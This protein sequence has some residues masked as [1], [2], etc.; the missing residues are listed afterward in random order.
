MTR[1]LRLGAT[2]LVVLAFTQ[3]MLAQPASID[4]ERWRAFA[5]GLESAARIEVRLRDGTAGASLHEG[6]TTG[7]LGGVS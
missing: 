5:E 4:A 1:Q 3:P 7:P 2:L 6:G